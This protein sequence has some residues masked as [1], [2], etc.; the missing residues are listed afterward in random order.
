MDKQ[1]VFSSSLLPD[2][3]SKT[4]VEAPQL[5]LIF[6]QDLGLVPK[7]IVTASRPAAR[8]AAERKWLGAD[9]SHVIVSQ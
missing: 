9:F 8:P 2:A 7:R 3:R 5:D 1:P 4:T 6:V